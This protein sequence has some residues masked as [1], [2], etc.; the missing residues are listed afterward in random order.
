M[1][2]AVVVW[3]FSYA[4]GAA[5]TTVALKLLWTQI[6]YLTLPGA[7]LFYF[8]FALAYSHHG[9]YLTKRNIILLAI[10]PTL[11]VI[12]VLTSNWHH[13]FYTSIS[14]NPDNNLAIK[15]HG[16]WFWIHITYCY[17][18]LAVGAIL[19]SREIRRTSI[20]FKPQIAILLVGAFLPFIGN[21]MYVFQINPIPGLDWTPIAFGLSGLILTWGIYR[22]QLLNLIPVARHKLVETI[23]DGILVLDV[24]GRIVDLNPAM[25]TITGLS[26]KQ[27]I[28][29]VA[30]EALTESPELIK[31]LDSY[32][33]LPKEICLGKK[34]TENY[35]VL[36]ILPL[37][38]RKG[39][40]AGPLIMLRNITAR[41]QNE[42]A[43]RKAHT[44]LE[45][46]VE[47]R[48]KELKVS[49][50]Q[51]QQEI[52]VRKQAEEEL[53]SHLEWAQMSY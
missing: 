49:N 17:T 31:R 19:L 1:E 45:E 23:R 11:T 42:K 24:H 7:P 18:L 14:I 15:E 52:T 20:F 48:T 43:L 28:G 34:G 8:L 32:N 27:T 30:T 12:I 39:Q 41:K 9:R 40:P 10:V 21:M 38:S 13:W 50:V 6:S 33:G 51:L 3:T 37:D 36:Q 53:G 16:F 47:Q 26:T 35:Y 25:Q 46:R 22:F 29:H 4:F 2:I 44:E 5:A